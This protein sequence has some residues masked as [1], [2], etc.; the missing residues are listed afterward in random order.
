MRLL[1]A[2][3]CD[4]QP[5]R[6][7]L[8]DLGLTSNR[9]FGLAKTDEEWSEQLETALTASRRYDLKHGSTPAYV[10]ACRCSDCREYQRIRMAKN[11]L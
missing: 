5:F 11:G 4:G 3:I 2:A 9:V 7:V 1:L 8:S 10:R 6:T